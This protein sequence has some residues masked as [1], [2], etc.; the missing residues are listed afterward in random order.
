MNCVLC[1]KYAALLFWRMYKN[2]EILHNL[3]KHSDQSQADSCASR[4]DRIISSTWC[5]SSGL[6][7]Q[8]M[9][10]LLVAIRN[11]LMTESNAPT[12]SLAQLG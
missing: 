8:I 5:Y 10:S 9:P 3:M 12:L 11:N 7:S 1:R 4:A 2:T 6:I